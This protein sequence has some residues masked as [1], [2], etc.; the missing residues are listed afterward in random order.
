MGKP[1]GEA[2]D[3]RFGH[4]HQDEPAGQ[5]SAKQVFFIRVFM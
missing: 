5:L 4:E 1:V 3:R 2:M